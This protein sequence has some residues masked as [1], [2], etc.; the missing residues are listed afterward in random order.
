MYIV[1]DDKSLPALP[2]T[3]TKKSGRKNNKEDRKIE[4]N[5]DKEELK[6]MEN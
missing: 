5:K 4:I 1:K 3:K 6:M 2:H